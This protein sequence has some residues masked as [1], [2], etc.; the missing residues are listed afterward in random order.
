MGSYRF[1]RRVWG[2]TTRTGSTVV[3]RNGGTASRASHGRGSCSPARV[4]RRMSQEEAAALRGGGWPLTVGSHR[5]RSCSRTARV[6]KPAADKFT[7][8]SEFLA[9]Q[10]DLR[11]IFTSFLIILALALFSVCSFHFF[12]LGSTVPTRISVPA[13]PPTHSQ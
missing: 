3:T 1:S 4:P 6:F 10:V 8:H 9:A 2:A 13:A 11:S 7:V 5:S 12:A